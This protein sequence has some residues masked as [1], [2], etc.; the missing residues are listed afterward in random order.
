MGD[1]R[2]S[3]NDVVVSVKH[4]VIAVSWMAINQSVSIQI[5]LQ[6]HVSLLS[7]APQLSPEESASC[8][9]PERFWAGK[10]IS[11]LILLRGLNECHNIQIGDKL[12][13]RDPPEEY[14][15]RHG[16]PNEGGVQITVETF[17]VYETDTLVDILW[18]NGLRETVSSVALV[19][20]LN[21]D[22]YDCWC[23]RSSSL[24]CTLFNVAQGPETMLYGKLKTP[25]L[26]LSCNL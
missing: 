5:L 11:K 13:L 12:T 2:P 19:P 26:Q 22:E 21:P 18:Q 8:S 25:L 15:T 6:T 7:R 3:H 9:R 14:L 24:L 1:V 10:D 4:T 23:V 17:T 16:K 20:Y